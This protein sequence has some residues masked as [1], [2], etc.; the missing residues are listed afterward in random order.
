ML[1]YIVALWTETWYK[2]IHVM[3]ECFN[4]KKCNSIIVTVTWVCNK[5]L[6]NLTACITLDFNNTLALQHKICA[7]I[8]LSHALNYFWSFNSWSFNFLAGSAIQ[9]IT[10]WIY[11]I[12]IWDL[13]SLWIS[14]SITL[15]IDTNILFWNTSSLSRLCSGYMQ[16]NT[17]L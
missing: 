1:A 15:V 16:S 11:P 6:T 13:Y 5:I 2:N 8:H 17:I 10:I 7:L 12:C 14:E 9:G 4:F 3:Y